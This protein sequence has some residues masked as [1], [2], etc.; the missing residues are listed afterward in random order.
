MEAAGN[1][2]LFLDWEDEIEDDSGEYVVLEEGDY[3]FTV[4]D[5]ER[6]RSKGGGKIP[7]CNMAVLT[8]SVDAGN[9]KTAACKTNILLYKTLE[10]KI[11]SFFRAIGSK[12][13]GQRV[14]MDWN[15][16]IGATGRA[17]F[18]PRSYTNQNGEERQANEVDYFIDY[19]EKL[20][21]KPAEPGFMA[22]SDA[23]AEELPFN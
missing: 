22:V 9:G 14:K 2:N 16:V 3:N 23:E 7:P 8:L 21:P 13:E 15:K 5:M 11:S 19:D 1:E 17:H 4:S 20:T 18:K 6:G 10:W 12:K